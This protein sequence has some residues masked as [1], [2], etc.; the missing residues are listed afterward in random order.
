[1][2]GGLSK[3]LVPDGL[4]ALV[5]PLLPSFAA[6]PQGGG[7]APRDER[8]VFTAVV[9]V[10]TSECAW[11][12]LPYTFGVSPATAHRRFA[13][14]TEA[15]VWRRLHRAVLDGLGARDELDWASVIVD[16]AAAR[17]RR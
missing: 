16:A 1:M 2:S 10:L 8:G 11:R 13:M 12:Q 6:R 7:T 17:A 9:Y 15:G 3:R 14:W 5:A 4:W